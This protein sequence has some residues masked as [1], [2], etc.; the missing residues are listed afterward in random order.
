MPHVPGMSF[1][2][3]QATNTH[4]ARNVV[5]LGSAR[6]IAESGLNVGIA[7]VRSQANWRY[8]QI[9]GAWLAE[10]PFAGGSFALQFQDETDSD[11]ADDAADQVTLTSLGLFGNT[12]ARIVVV[13]NSPPATRNVGLVSDGNIALDS[14]SEI[15]SFDSTNGAY[16]GPNRGQAAQ[17]ATNTT[18]TNA[19]NINS[20]S[21]IRGDVQVGPGGD[22]SN[23]I[24]PV[25]AVTGSTGT[26]SAAF[27]MPVI[28]EPTGMGASIGDVTYASSATLGSDLHAD[29]IVVDAGSTLQIDGDLKILVE[30]N[31]L[32]NSG[33][34]IEILAGGSLELYV[35]G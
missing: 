19:V 20:A 21:W 22:P 31:F 6:A 33:G 11:L 12:R 18:A 28:S 30:D 3:A 27:P 9:H 23:V 25:G 10:H 8:E 26:Q 14:E 5:N 17:V 1:L 4:V 29:N 32:L 15:D 35:K 13:I 24:N 16:G 34:Q 7:Y 2:S